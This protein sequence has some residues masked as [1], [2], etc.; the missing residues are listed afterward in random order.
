MR[1]SQPS[2]PK[3]FPNPCPRALSRHALPRALIHVNLLFLPHLESVFVR[4]RPHLKRLVF[5][6]RIFLLV[7]NHQP[8]SRTPPAFLFD[9]ANLVLVQK[10][11][12]RHVAHKR[13]DGFLK[14]AP[15]V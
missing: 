13:L 14:L 4:L 1:F 11:G 6:V 2:I 15:L 10:F 9:G 3:V 7:L 8:L 12:K 5:Q